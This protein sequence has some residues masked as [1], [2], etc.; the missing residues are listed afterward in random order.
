MATFNPNT[1]IGA[2][3]IGSTVMTF[4]LGIVTHQA[5]HCMYY[6]PRDPLWLKSLVCLVWL[7]AASQTISVAAAMYFLTVTHF[8]DF[9]PE[10]MN[11]I[12]TGFVWTI[13]L[14]GVMTSLVQTMLSAPSPSQGY[15]AHRIRLLSKRLYIPVFC[16]S[17]STLRFAGSVYITAGALRAQNSSE[18]LRDSDW[19]L[20]SILIGGACLDIII[21]AS[22]CYY[23]K[24]EKVFALTRM[25]KTLDK[26]M[27]YS[28]ET[29]LLTGIT[30]VT[31]YICYRFIRSAYSFFAVFMSFSE[32]GLSLCPR[33]HQADTA[34]SI[35]D[36]YAGFLKLAQSSQRRTR[37]RDL[38][39][40]GKCRG[41]DVLIS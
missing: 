36:Y 23:L 38:S 21:A 17:M 34:D 7:V 5:V 10:D 27:V 13:V 18:F 29:G 35:C 2:T 14:S 11:Q 30:G 32:G 16:W 26:L 4:L 40:S 22:M 31:I 6:Y 8:G 28:I 15:Y 3:Q 41:R 1:S 9:S 19:L 24:R 33:D 20:A 25:A 39:P 12:P 37:G